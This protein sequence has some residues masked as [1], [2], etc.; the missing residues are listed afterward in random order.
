M[1]GSYNA[2]KIRLQDLLGVIYCHLCTSRASI[3]L[4]IHN[5]AAWCLHHIPLHGIRVDTSTRIDVFPC[6]VG[7]EVA[8]SSQFFLETTFRG[9]GTA[10]KAQCIPKERI[11]VAWASVLCSYPRM[12]PF[13]TCLSRVECMNEIPKNLCLSSSPTG[14]RPQSPHSLGI[15]KLS[16]TSS[17]SFADTIVGVTDTMSLSEALDGHLGYNTD[18]VGANTAGS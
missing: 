16:E 12:T 11:S 8:I 10:L 5:T 17:A 14:Q 15:T 2:L 1:T 4:A 18:V 7:A 9:I 13:E 6:N 3:R